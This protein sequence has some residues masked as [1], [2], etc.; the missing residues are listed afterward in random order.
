MEVSYKHSVV[1]RKMRRIC[2]KV[3]STYSVTSKCRRRVSGRKI[4]P[5]SLTWKMLTW[6]R[7]RVL[8]MRMAVEVALIRS[9]IWLEM[10]RTRRTK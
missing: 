3:Q 6:R 7:S 8:G 4:Q 2:G 9:M 10:G 1:S 5:Y